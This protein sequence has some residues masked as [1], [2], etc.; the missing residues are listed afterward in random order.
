MLRI[1]ILAFDARGRGELQQTQR[2][3]SVRAVATAYG[4]PARVV[5]RAISAGELPAILTTTETGRE[6]AYI[7]ASDAAHWFEAL[8]Q[9]REK[10]RA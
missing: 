4:I 5:S 3:M 8:S 2:R 1:G 7:S 10:V 6:R 9:P